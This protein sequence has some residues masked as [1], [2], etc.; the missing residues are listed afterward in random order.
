M[1][2]FGLAILFSSWFLVLNVAQ[3]IESQPSS[4]NYS[5]L[6]QKSLSIK[7]KIRPEKVQL[8]EPVTLVI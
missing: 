8:G 4:V 7:V 6:V 3:A 2:K 1:V 5:K